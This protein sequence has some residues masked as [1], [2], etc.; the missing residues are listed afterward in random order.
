VGAASPGTCTL[1]NPQELQVN[2]D[3]TS[4]GYTPQ[5]AGDR[6]TGSVMSL[7]QQDCY[8]PTGVNNPNCCQQS[9]L[10]NGQST[11]VCPD[12]CQI[13]IELVHACLMLVLVV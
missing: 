2:V 12:T 11:Q 8:L 3:L 10:K 6:T 5:Y 7:S 9:T 1:L 13:C 4:W